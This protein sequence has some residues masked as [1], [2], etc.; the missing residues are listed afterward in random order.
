ML[1]SKKKTIPRKEYLKLKE[2]YKFELLRKDKE[3]EKLKAE[4][5]VILKTALKQAKIGIGM[6]KG[7]KD[8]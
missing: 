5:E 3:I 1:I 8:E 4:K 2:W 6:K 7:E